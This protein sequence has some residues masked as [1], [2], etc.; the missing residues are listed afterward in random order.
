[1]NKLSLPRPVYDLI[2]QEGKMGFEQ[3]LIEAGIN[4]G[5]T[6]A[7]INEN[8]IFLDDHRR[9]SN[10][11][12]IEYVNQLIAAVHGYNSQTNHLPMKKGLFVGLQEAEFHRTVSAGDLLTIHGVTMEE[13]SQVNFVRGIITR[14][15]VKVAELVTKL[16][17]MPDGPEF[18]SLIHQGQSLKRA[19][20]II[21]NHQPPAFLASGMQRKLY[22]YLD[23]I[24]ADENC[25]SFTMAC[26]SDFDA[27]NGHFPENPILPGV[28]LVEIA[29]L[30][31]KL[32]FDK[33]AVIQSIKKM[34]IGGV[35]LP[36]QPVSCTVTIDKQCNPPFSYSAIYRVGATGGTNGDRSREI[37]RFNGYYGFTDACDEGKKG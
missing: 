35:V 22:G 16:Y 1:M 13:I 23:H 4:H 14:D 19:D 31:L 10:A 27:F 28:V 11:V 17:E 18:R 6:T 37:S 33:P 15:G 30:A 21:S 20:E 36:N 7:I 32:L 25:I 34:K 9:L 24:Q 12:L 3:T 5:E 29:D 26:P 2:P 8:N